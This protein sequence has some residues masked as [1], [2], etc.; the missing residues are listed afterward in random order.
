VKTWR[1]LLP[2]AP[3]AAALGLALYGCGNGL[4]ESGPV[5]VVEVSGDGQAAR[6]G[7]PLPEPLVVRVTD[8]RGK[9]LAHRLVTWTVVAG[10]GAFGDYFDSLDRDH[11]DHDRQWCWPESTM[12]V[13]TDEDGFARASFTPT[14]FGPSTVTASAP[15]AH[16]PPVTFTADASDPGAV[17]TIVSGNDQEGKTSEWVDFLIVKVMDGEGRPVPYIT[18]TWAV[19]EG[20][21]T[22]SGCDRTGPERASITSRSSSDEWAVGHSLIELRLWTFGTTRVAA[23]VP[24][25]AVSPVTF[26]A[27]ATVIV[28]GLSTSWDDV[29][30]FHGLETAPV[31]ATVEFLNHGSSARI[32][33]T[34]VPQGSDGFDSGDLGHF[35]R[36]QFVP[37]LPGTWEFVDQVSGAS[38]TLIVVE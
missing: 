1:G 38:G 10:E 36:F 26:T 13:R 33:S 30:S 22:I 17:L 8:H 29:T 37:D 27:E 35:D 12:S 16:G 9:G 25:V 11:W 18:I 2:S 4:L 20:G 19:T 23:S 28:I 7:Y 31:G 5:V 14:W 15:D 32:V 21:G 24:G 3:L 6:A 34:S